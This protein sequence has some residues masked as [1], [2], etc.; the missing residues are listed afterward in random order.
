MFSSERSQ[1]PNNSSAE[2]LDILGTIRGRLNKNPRRD[3]HS[4]H[5]SSLRQGQTDP[6]RPQRKVLG[7]TL[8]ESRDLTLSDHTEAQRHDLP[9]MT[10]ARI[11]AG[12]T[13]QPTSWQLL[14]LH[15]MLENL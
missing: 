8:F 5:V 3:D 12:L 11:R 13:E 14:V 6:V 10:S 15:W 9:S 7:P 1:A 2:W 4:A